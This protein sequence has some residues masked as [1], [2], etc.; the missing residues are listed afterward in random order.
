MNNLTLLMGASMVMG[1]G[2]VLANSETDQIQQV[3]QQYEQHLNA[4]NSGEIM[5]LYGEAPV[6]MPQHAPAQVGRNEVQNA[7]DGVFSQIKL[8]VKFTTHEI[9][10]VGD[11][12]AWARTSS[13]GK[14]TILANQAV[15]DEGNS[16]LFVF[17][18]EHDSWKIHRYIF[19]TTTPMQSGE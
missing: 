9:E 1:S 16:E 6:F 8:K 10:L 18:K 4:G 17:K 12:T 15:I 2:D 5:K 7:Y 14:T 13:A 19:T 11:N 3:L